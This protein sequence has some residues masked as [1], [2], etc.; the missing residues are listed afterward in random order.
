[1]ITVENVSKDYGPRR[2]LHNLSFEVKQGEVLG[3]LGPNG[4]GKTT[5]M[6]ILTGFFP[7]TEG[8]VTIAGV[9]FT[10]ARK[11]LKLHIGYL[12]EKISLYPDFRV[13]EFL[14]W[15]AEVKGVARPKRKGEA[16]EK[17]ELCGLNPVAKRLIGHLSKGFLQRVGLAQAL[18]GDPHIL[19]L[20]EPTSGLDPKQIIE[21]R[22]LIRYLG[23]DRTLILSTHILPEVSRVCERVLILNQGRIVAQGRPD[24]LEGRLRDC[25]EIL[26]RVQSL[27][28][29]GKKEESL[30]RV[31]LAIPGVE[32]LQKMEEED[33]VSTFLLTGALDVDLRSEISKRVIQAGY[34]LL[35]LAAKRL[36]LEDIFLKL[37]M[38]EERAESL[39]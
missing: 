11:D 8:R 23:H 18:M 14:E 12:P 3:F 5:V 4:A 34:P 33:S 38:S 36:S 35:E 20:D 7:P 25:Q 10:K 9:D 27:K 6:R 29:E 24:E 2:V 13:D 31:L 16:E 15:V 22:E 30:G 39:K 17:M 26:V 19:I 21:I 37:V 32:S 28:E 1:M